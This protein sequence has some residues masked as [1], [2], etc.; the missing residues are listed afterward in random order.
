MDIGNNILIS[1][2]PYKGLHKDSLKIHELFLDVKMEI[3]ISVKTQKINIYI[4]VSQFTQQLQ[5][6]FEKYLVRD[7]IQ[8]LNCVIYN[9]NV[10]KKVKL[11]EIIDLQLRALLK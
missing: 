7:T 10:K 6:K 3:C 2:T 4:T 8:R 1:P 9:V 5:K 11:V